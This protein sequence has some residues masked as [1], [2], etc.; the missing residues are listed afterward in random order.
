MSLRRNRYLPWV[1]AAVGVVI[2]VIAIVIASQ[3][4]DAPS[5]AK[6]TPRI[7]D[8]QDVP[9]PQALTLEEAESGTKPLQADQISLQ[10]GAWVQVADDTGRLEQQYQACVFPSARLKAV[11]LK[12]M[13]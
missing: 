3:V 7:V 13:L 6:R 9:K 2:G 5:S 1:A 8:A 11:S 4:G 12:V 10:S